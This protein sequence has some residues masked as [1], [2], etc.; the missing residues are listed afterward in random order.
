MGTFFLIFQIAQGGRWTV[1]QEIS[2]HHI[3]LN[4]ENSTYYFYDA[5]YSNFYLDIKV[6]GAFPCKSAST[7]A[8]PWG[9]GGGKGG[10]SPP[11]DFKKGENEKYDV[12]SGIK[13]IKISFSVIFNE[14]IRDLEGLLSWF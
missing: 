8:A 14:E 13:V 3:M 11:K 4:H 7:G 1:F 12:F 2:S 10:K 6:N 5:M 9:G